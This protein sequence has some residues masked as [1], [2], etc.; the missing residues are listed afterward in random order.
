MPGHSFGTCFRIAPTNY[1]PTSLLYHLVAAPA[2]GGIF[3]KAWITLTGV[4]L[5]GAGISSLLEQTRSLAA[6][7]EA[8]NCSQDVSLKN[9]MCSLTLK[10]WAGYFLPADG[11]AKGFQVSG[12]RE[13]KRPRRNFYFE[14]R[15]GVM[16][17]RPSGTSYIDR[18]VIAKNFL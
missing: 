11:L 7:S 9:V 1:S 18:V 3:Q 12:D 2:E 6:K 8:G 13:A 10:S 5:S 17:G 16:A 14:R 15:L 4:A